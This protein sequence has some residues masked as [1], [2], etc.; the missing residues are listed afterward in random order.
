[1]VEFAAEAM[2]LAGDTVEFSEGAPEVDRDTMELVASPSEPRRQL[3][4]LMGL[5]KRFEWKVR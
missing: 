2:G 1:M 5:K 4:R 3:G